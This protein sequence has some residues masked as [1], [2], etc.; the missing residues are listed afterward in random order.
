MKIILT[1]LFLILINITLAQDKQSDVLNEILSIE[2]AREQRINDFKKIN[3]K[4]ISLNENGQ[5]WDIINGRPVYIENYNTKAAKSTRTNFLKPEG[6]LN[7]NLQGFD[8]DIGIW[9]VGGI[10]QTNHPEFLNNLGQSKIIQKDDT[11]N[12][13]FHATHVAGTLIATGVA[14]AAEGMAPGATLSSYD[15]TRD[16]NEAFQAARDDDMIL[17]NHSYGI[18]IRNLEGNE[19]FMGAYSENSRVWDE[20][21]NSFPN[22]LAVFSA[23]NDG[24][25]IYEGGFEDGIDKLTGNKT[26]KNVLVV[27]NSRII[28]VDS[29][30]GEFTGASINPSSSQGPTDDGRIKP[31]ITGLGTDILSSAPDGGYASATGTS[32]SAPNVT[33][34]ALLLQELYNNLEN[35]F[36]LASTLKGLISVT[37]DD[38]GEVGPDPYFGWGVMNTK[39]SA[40]AILNNDDGDIIKEDSLVSG[41]NHR[42]RIENSTGETM[43]VAI[44]W[45]DPAGTSVS[46]TLNDPTPVLVNDLDIR[47]S[48]ISNEEQYLPWKLD[49]DDVSAA[50]KTGDNKVDNIEVIEIDDQGVFDVSIT[51]KSD[52]KNGGQKYS[53]IILNGLQQSLSN[54]EFNSAE[55]SLWPNPVKTNLNITSSEV[56]FGNDTKV[57]IYDMLGREVLNQQGF[58]S[59]SNL[60]IDMSTLSKGIY[61]LNLTD[62]MQSIQKRI[63]KE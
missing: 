12:I 53:L 34:S 18:P 2:N 44:A 13:I 38:E 23:G 26:A 40:E 21:S 30:T 3:P 19:W 36:M 54:S 17:S 32:M 42:L 7:L 41:E 59:E 5:L 27:A 25:V 62:G 58:E 8:L 45:N 9:E 52:L 31:D 51:H 10:P 14:D 46:D 39:R 57:L 16:S 48:N 28:L 49:I 24:N 6:S 43:E 35:K 15:V 55:I 22:Y 11:S 60:S 63:I 47:I 61:I 37:A 1:A 29:N 20:I 56:N 33:G 4:A 50:A